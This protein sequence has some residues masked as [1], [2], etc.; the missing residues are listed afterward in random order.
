MKPTEMMRR[1]SWN[2]V[3]DNPE[4]ADGSLI[5]QDRGEIGGQ[6]ARFPPPRDCLCYALSVL[7]ACIV[8]KVI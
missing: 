8:L 2:N 5:S 6:G 3:A 7:Y 1:V 4:S